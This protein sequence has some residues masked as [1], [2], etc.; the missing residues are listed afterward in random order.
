MNERI[1]R[2]LLSVA[3]SYALVGIK[4]TGKFIAINDAENTT[5]EFDV[6]AN[7]KV[8]PSVGLNTSWLGHKVSFKENSLRNT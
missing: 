1:V 3:K 6:D 5:V 8:L 2:V 4:R 7:V